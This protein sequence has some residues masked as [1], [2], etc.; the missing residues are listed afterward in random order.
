MSISSL[1]QNDTL[2]T[3]PR[4]TN[5]SFDIG[6]AAQARQVL[7]LEFTTSPVN[8]AALLATAATAAAWNKEKGRDPALYNIYPLAGKNI[9][10]TRHVDRPEEK[11]L[12]AAQSPLR[13]LAEEDN[14][15][16]ELRL[17][18]HHNSPKHAASNNNT[19]VNKPRRY[20]FNVFE[21]AQSLLRLRYVANDVEQEDVEA[22]FGL[23]DFRYDLR[24]GGFEQQ[25]DDSSEDETENED[26]PTAHP[27]ARKTRR[28]SC[29]Y[30]DGKNGGV[31]PRSAAAHEGNALFEL[32]SKRFVQRGGDRI[33]WPCFFFQDSI[34]ARYER[35]YERFGYGGLERE[36]TVEVDDDAAAAAVAVKYDDEGN[37]HRG[38]MMMVVSKPP[39][40]PL[41]S[42]KTLDKL[43]KEKREWRGRAEF[44]PPPPPLPATITTTTRERTSPS[45]TSS[46]S[47]MSEA[48]R[49]MRASLYAKESYIRDPVI[50]SA[51]PD[52]TTP[53]Y[54]NN[55]DD[56]DDASSR[57]RRQGR[58]GGFERRRRRR[59]KGS[60]ALI[61]SFTEDTPAP[62]KHQ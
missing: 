2:Q 12:D 38:D 30:C 3:P 43:E 62:L 45:F 57:P 21:T 5:T 56:D 18:D 9:N 34:R 31:Q 4:S 14:Q 58:L 26:L 42:Q 41:L 33:C 39:P 20:R 61:H 49:L 40:P 25:L 15:D 19:E 1:L 50:P 36:E 17:S 8:D 28:R 55:N 13:L 44:D 27:T 23:V 24:N 7:G 51:P 22:A 35:G 48:A 32:L 29:T 53:Q 59:R 60:V 16:P 37:H 47:V 11:N 10:K 54:V 52:A 6:N 46:V